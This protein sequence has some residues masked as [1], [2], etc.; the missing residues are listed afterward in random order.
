M[1]QFYQLLGNRLSAINGRSR[2]AEAINDHPAVAPP[3]VLR[4]FTPPSALPRPLMA[5][6]VPAIVESRLMPQLISPP[7][8]R[9]LQATRAFLAS[10]LH[11]PAY[12]L[13]SCQKHYSWSSAASSFG[14]ETS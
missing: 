9:S 1:M 4:A 2:E 14:S 6:T 13:L 10:E 8:R 11:S 12:S 3:A 5:E 7:I